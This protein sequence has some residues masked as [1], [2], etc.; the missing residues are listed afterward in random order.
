M[1]YEHARA[2][3]ELFAREVMPKARGLR[4]AAVSVAG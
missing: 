3:L 4:G 1:P 2:S